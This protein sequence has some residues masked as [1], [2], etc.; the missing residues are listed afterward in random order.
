[1]RRGHRERALR[2]LNSFAA[3]I[4]DCTEPAAVCERT[5]EAADVILD[6]DICVVN[7]ESDGLLEVRAI[8]DSTPPEDVEPM[9][10][11]EGLV[12]LTYRTGESYLVADLEEMPAAEPKG[13]YRSAVSVPVG[14]HGTFQTVAETPDAFDETDVELAEL[15]STHCAAALDRIERAETVP[16]ALGFEP[17]PE[18]PHHPFP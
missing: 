3:E 13:P 2:A 9:G 18:R 4:A 16:A 10:V 12:G 17:R 6:F 11:D 8:S 7:L 15:L 5:V 14:D 1:M